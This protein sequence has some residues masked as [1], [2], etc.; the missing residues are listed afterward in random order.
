MIPRKYTILAAKKTAELIKCCKS[1]Q[2]EVIIFV[3]ARFHGE[4]EIFRDAWP[5]AR[6]LAIEA[7][8]KSAASANQMMP[9]THAAIVENE[10][11]TVTLYKRIG[12]SR[13][14]SIYPDKANKYKKLT[15]PAMTLDQF[16]RQHKLLGKKIFLWMDCEGS[17]LSAMKGGKKLLKYV[18]W[19]HLEV[20]VGDTRQG[21]PKQGEIQTFLADNKY[22]LV[23]DYY[24]LD[25]PFR[26]ADM[27]YRQQRKPKR[28]L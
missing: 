23:I 25:K 20:S 12:L 28:L 15:V 21:G 9:T 3:G 22:E 10:C 17:E 16:Y 26:S 18:E 11:K 27:L 14:S 7:Y 4:N 13:A 1:C 24:Q 5:Q 19:I 2:P 6:Q 8:P